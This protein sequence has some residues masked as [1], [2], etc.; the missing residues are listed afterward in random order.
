M[1]SGILG[2]V[3]AGC[4][5]LVAAR[6]GERLGEAGW[7][8]GGALGAGAAGV[9]VPLAMGGCLKPLRNTLFL[10]VVGAAFA[11]ALNWWIGREIEW[12]FYRWGLA[13]AA[14]GILLGPACQSVSLAS[15]GE[16]EMKG[17]ARVLFELSLVLGGL[18]KVFNR[19]WPGAMVAGFFAGAL[20]GAVSGCVV[21]V[22]GGKK[23]EELLGGVPVLTACGA[24][25]GAV[26]GAVGG[27]IVF[28]DQEVQRRADQEVQRSGSG[29]HGRCHAD[30]TLIFLTIR[31]C[32]LRFSSCGSF[33]SS[34]ARSDAAAPRAAGNSPRWPPASDN[35]VSI[36]LASPPPAARCPAPPSTSRTA[37]S[38]SRS[39]WSSRTLC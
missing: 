27:W 24:V 28:A 22:C 38:S 18:I 21:A 31:I 4:V 37:G 29:L 2:G 39:R 14:L 34:S 12:T 1:V 17:K 36:G 26:G 33:R 8:A 5:G 9:V 15:G 35:G 23:A 20:G 30:N 19:R 10:F 6:I 16:V 25:L 13:G 3:A 11:A 32:P 7:L